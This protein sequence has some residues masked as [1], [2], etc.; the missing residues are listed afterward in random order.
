MNLLDWII[1]IWLI[2]AFL[3]GARLGLVY[4][5]GHLLGFGFGLWL[6]GRYVPMIASWFNG[7][8]V[9]RVVLFIFVLVVVA[10]VAGVVAVTANKF[11]HIFAFLPFAKTTN[12]LLGGVTGLVGH[13]LIISAALAVARRFIDT[14]LFTQ[15][16]IDSTLGNL[17]ALVGDWLTIFLPSW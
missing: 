16:I 15:T 11:F 12:A 10:E 7:G 14:P 17:L 4:R 13:S 8:V 3:L 9:W 1:I 2:I 6:A 5:I